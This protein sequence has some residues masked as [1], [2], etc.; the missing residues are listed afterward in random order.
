MLLLSIETATRVG[1]VALVDENKILAEYVVN[2]AK[3]HVEQLLKGI[4]K[5]LDDRKKS[6]VASLALNRLIRKQYDSVEALVP[7]YL[8][9]SDAEINWA[10]K[11]GHQAIYH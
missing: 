10:K 7:K 1:S 11:H 9:L 2:S 5:I 8:H 6:D 3:S 4:N